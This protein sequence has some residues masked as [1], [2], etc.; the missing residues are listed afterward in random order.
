M[1]LFF[2]PI[3]YASMYDHETMLETVTLE[4]E[5]DQ[6]EFIRNMW[7]RSVVIFCHMGGITREM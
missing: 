2:L 6:A 7:N 3:V 4:S 1:F 5:V